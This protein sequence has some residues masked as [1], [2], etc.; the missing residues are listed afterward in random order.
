MLKRLTDRETIQKILWVLV[1]AGLLASL[2]LAALRIQTEQ[3][4]RKVE[5][6][7]DYQDLLTIAHYQANPAR[8]VETELAKMQ[9]AGITSIAVYESTLYELELQHRVS[10]FTS[11]EVSAYTDKRPDPDEN[12][13]YVAFAAEEDYESMRPVIE[14][15]FDSQGIETHPWSF[16]GRS[17]LVVEAPLQKAEMVP[18]DPDPSVMEELR[19]RGFQVVVRLSDNRPFDIEALHRLFAHLSAL[20]VRWI[21]FS[22]NQVTGFEAEAKQPALTALADL[23]NRS[24]IGM[25][26]IELLN[27][28]QKGWKSSHI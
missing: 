16:R 5:I 18:M 27:I 28:P 9:Q 12:Y 21:I 25:A 13:T 17:G 24:G 2:P 11:E 14:R 22:G 7:Y 23:M 3:S 19:N 15:A 4:A 1:A 26:S 6:V 20:D 10:L 8:F